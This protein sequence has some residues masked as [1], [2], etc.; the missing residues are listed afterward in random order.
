MNTV[1]RS[2]KA[3]VA[4]TDKLLFFLCV[5]VS[6]FGVLMVHSAT[7]NT[8][9]DG[10]R[11]SR[12]TII[13]MIA[14]SIGIL[15]CLLISSVDYALII[16]MW[17][18]IT[19]VCVALMLSL[20]IWGVGPDYRSDAKSWLQIAGVNFQ[21]S[22]LLKI[23]FIITFTFHLDTVKDRVNTFKNIAFLC[24]HGMLPIGLVI[25]TGDLGSALVFIAIFIGM[26]FI[27]GVHFRYF[28]G[29]LA[30]CLVA[31][32]MLWISFFSEFQKQRFLAVYYPKAMSEAVYKALIYQQQ[33]SINAIGSGQLLG[34]GLFKGS[35]TQNG[36][37]PVDESDMIFAVIGEELG[38]LGCAATL[39]ILAVIIGRIVVVGNK[40]KDNIGSLVCY[41]IALMI[42]AQS[43]INIG[44]CMKLLPCIGITLPFISSG[45]SSNLCVYIGIGM[46]MSIFRANHELKPVN[47]RLSHIRTPFSEQ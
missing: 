8:L 42:G 33:Q 31:V 5:I 40:A 16:K 24:L 19:I 1:F 15:L 20:F 12:D 23:G 25:L 14:I 21:P 26:L 4:E 43:I 32:P 7:R 2:V 18:V 9:A 37:I 44:M 17:P 38:F 41:G 27:A 22:E 30:V 11:F 13:M 6:S 10:E 35:F 28:A 45:G 29:G 39:L 36:M 47:F 3:Y 46:I 34:K